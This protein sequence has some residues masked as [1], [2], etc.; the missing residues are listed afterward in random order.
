M[1][2]RFLAVATVFGLTTG[3]ALAQSSSTDST[4]STQTTAA[5]PVD[6]TYDS[7][8]TQNSVD[9]N[10]TE[11]DKSQSYSGGAGGSDAKSNSQTISPDGSA[12]TS[13]QS[14]QRTAPPP[15]PAD[16]TTT[17]TGSTTTTA[18]N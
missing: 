6:G 4:S 3:V 14:E 13:S 11:T 8:K 2:R 16:T 5:P 12:V 18:P 7:T 1:L 17:T 10:G 9:A 15:P